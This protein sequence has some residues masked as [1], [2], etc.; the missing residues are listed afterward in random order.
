M[1]EICNSE[2]QLR[3]LSKKQI[4]ACNTLY[5]APLFAG[6]RWLSG[7]WQCNF[8]YIFQ[9]ESYPIQ[10][11]FD[12]GSAKGIIRCSSAWLERLTNSLAGGVDVELLPKQLRIA[13]AEAAFSELAEQIE[14][15]GK[16]RLRITSVLVDSDPLTANDEGNAMNGLQW[17]AV[18]DGFSY[19][20]EVW[21][22]RNGLEQAAEF[23]RFSKPTFFVDP[24]W[25]ALPVPIRFLIGQTTLSPNAFLSLELNDVV[26]LD[27]SWL[28]EEGVLTVTLCRGI[29][30]QARLDGALLTVMEG[31]KEMM[32]DPNEDE[33]FDHDIGDSN[34]ISAL[35]IR[36]TFDLGER[37]MQIGELQSLQP[38]YVFDLGRDLR[39]AV[40]IRANG[41]R[42]GEGELV[43]ISGR[44][45]VVVLSLSGKHE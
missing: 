42:V 21:L 28:T 8:Q 29:A 6:A 19:S 9:P 30:F 7:E 25:I 4:S 18:C 20:G 32:D 39:Q 10:I 31:L 24:R 13:L 26:L 45:G 35:P 40:I 12:W 38:G 37:S 15:R 2:L 1:P 16:K 23:N 36:L 22:D 43:D 11:N 3:S 27:D 34:L 17:Q 33:R 5:R 44:T 14:A 41:I